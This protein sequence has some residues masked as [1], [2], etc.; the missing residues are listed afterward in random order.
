MRASR[1]RY[2]MLHFWA[3]PSGFGG[4]NPGVIIPS[5]IRCL[6][7]QSGPKFFLRIYARKGKHVSLAYTS[8]RYF[9]PATT[10]TA[11]KI[12]S[13]ATCAIRNGGSDCVGA[14]GIRNGNFWNACTPPTKA[15]K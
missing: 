3:I 1:I 2:Q 9:F 12:A 4:K 6:T 10:P 15:F 11:M 13:T 7:G 14:S 5:R 8:G